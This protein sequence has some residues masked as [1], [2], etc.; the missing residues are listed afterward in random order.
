MSAD[1]PLML[2]LTTL[3]KKKPLRWAL[4]GA[5]L[6]EVR[7]MIAIGIAG[8]I[9]LPPVVALWRFGFDRPAMFIMVFALAAGYFST[10]AKP[11][12]QS[13]PTYLIG[14]MLGRIGTVVIDGEKRPVYVGVARVRDYH[15]GQKFRLARSAVE[16]RPELLDERGALK[17]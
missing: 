6:L 17:T 9:A 13:I 16:V 15:G 7:Q 3:A 4:L 10:M 1:G 12:G 14:M 8:L 2:D 5:F 11:D